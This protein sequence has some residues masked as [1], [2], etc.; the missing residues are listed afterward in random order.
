MGKSVFFFN[1]GPDFNVFDAFFVHFPTV[2]AT[3]FA[4]VRPIKPDC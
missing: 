3:A 4:V 2:F 1:N